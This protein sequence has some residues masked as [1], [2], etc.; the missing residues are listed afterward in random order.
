METDITRYLRGVINKELPVRFYRTDSLPFVTT[1]KELWE[2]YDEVNGFLSV[3]DIVMAF[4]VSTLSTMSVQKAVTQ[5]RKLGTHIFDRYGTDNPYRFFSKEQYQV[6]LDRWLSSI[7]K[8]KSYE[9][10]LLDKIE[11]TNDRISGYPS[12]SIATKDIVE[13]NILFD[14]SWNEPAVNFD[15]IPNRDLTIQPITDHKRISQ[16]DTIDV[17]ALLKPSEDVPYIAYHSPQKNNYKVHVTTTYVE[18]GSGSIAV[19]PRRDEYS[20]ESIVSSELYS[21]LQTSPDFITMMVKGIF[22]ILDSSK[23]NVT[24]YSVKEVDAK[25]I[26]LFVRRYLYFLHLN[27]ERRLR[28][29]TSFI[30]LKNLIIYPILYAD[31]LFNESEYVYFKEEDTPQLE[32]NIKS[33]YISPIPITV[34]PETGMYKYVREFKVT[35]SNHVAV[36]NEFVKLINGKT[37]QIAKGENYTILSV[38][39]INNTSLLTFVGYLLSKLL[40][41][42]IHNIEQEYMQEFKNNFARILTVDLSRGDYQKKDDTVRTID[43]LYHKA[44][45]VFIKNYSRICQSQQQ[46]DIKDVISPDEEAS[47]DWLKFP[48]GAPSPEFYFSCASQSSSYVHAGVITN[49]LKNRKKYPLLPC[50]FKTSQIGNPK[51]DTYA[52]YNNPDS[53]S[54]RTLHLSRWGSLEFPPSLKK[55]TIMS[56]D[57]NLY[58]GRL[59]IVPRILDATLRGVIDEASGN[60]EEYEIYRYGLSEQTL[61]HAIFLAMDTDYQQL[62][63]EDFSKRDSYIRSRIKLPHMEALMQE[64][65][66]PQPEVLLVDPHSWT[67]RVHYR[68]LEEMFGINIFVLFRS[69]PKEGTSEPSRF[70]FE[71]PFSRLGYHVRHRRLDRPYVLLYKHS[72]YEGDVRVESPLELIIY[73]PIDGEPTALWGTSCKK[74]FNLYENS[75]KV[76]SAGFSPLEVS[77][78][79]YRVYKNIFSID[80]ATR[81][82][83]TG[84]TPNSQVVDDYGRCRALNYSDFSVIFYPTQSYNL[85]SGDLVKAEYKTVRKLFG[86]PDLVSSTKDGVFHLLGNSGLYFFFPLRRSATQSL[87]EKIQ[88]VNYTPMSGESK[89]SIKHNWNEAYSSLQI[90]LFIF[91][92]LYVLSSTISPEE[93]MKTFVKLDESKHAATVEDIYDFSKMKRIVILKK[94]DIETAKEY[95]RTTI[96]TIM[97]DDDHLLVTSQKIYNGL[98]YFLKTVDKQIESTRRSGQHQNKWDLSRL[99]SLIS[100]GKGARSEMTEGQN[101]F[102]NNVSSMKSWFQSRVSIT[103]GREDVQTI[104]EMIKNNTGVVIWK[105]PYSQRIWIIPTRTYGLNEAINICLHWFDERKVVDQQSVEPPDYSN[106]QSIIKY[107]FTLDN[108]I[109]IN[110]ISEHSSSGLLQ[111]EILLSLPS[112]YTP[113]LPL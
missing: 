10:L 106:I 103:F 58:R 19:K 99:F 14:L 27:G 49:K 4:C 7:R 20:Y 92:W 64:I 3:E 78:E 55:K 34:S 41:K 93:F 90:I 16:E 70:T 46:P 30:L 80:Y 32:K 44:P 13:S 62:S 52:A 113:L 59:G 104:S 108:R 6:S 76:I 48:P 60:S 35:I 53:E 71:I 73:G 8:E 105:H 26:E 82:V 47:G 5:I 65:D 33:F 12:A 95:L 87:P 36:N 2:T 56:E 96:P 86:E 88:E 66:N 110:E 51:S 15:D 23:S 109:E 107:V 61:V 25:D 67:P 79:M 28:I 91:S 69:S 22:C 83:R 24:L 42:Y 97:A 81:L 43:Y 40:G 101:L 68:I 9:K 75:Y 50:C 100:L 89:D 94:P 111:V 84:L 11:T 98:E 85:P 39:D 74:I 102:F 112:R 72:K 45:E 21:E 57:K 1:S 29:S 31:F 18:D 54:T 37:D 63:T 17:F 77:P 38:T